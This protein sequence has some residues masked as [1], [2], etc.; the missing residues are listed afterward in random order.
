MANA[1]S[2][3]FFP[4]DTPDNDHSTKN[5]LAGANG[6]DER[7]I[8][9]CVVESYGFGYRVELELDSFA[10]LFL[11]QA[12]LTIVCA[13]ITYPAFDLLITR[14]TD[15]SKYSS[16]GVKS[17]YLPKDGDFS[18]KKHGRLECFTNGPWR[19]VVPITNLLSQP[20]CPDR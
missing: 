8:L 14:N 15:W 13:D 20:I 4:H 16:I 3:F 7:H 17:I 12:N 9:N 2:I 10:R 11:D 6:L 1:F 5:H 19:F 18:E